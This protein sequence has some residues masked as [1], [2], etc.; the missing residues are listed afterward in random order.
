MDCSSP[1]SSVHGILQTRTLRWVAIPFSRGSSRARDRTCVSCTAGGLIATE[2]QGSLTECRG[3][4][5]AEPSQGQV[6]VTETVSGL[7][8]GARVGAP[9]NPETPLEDRCLRG[10]CAGRAGAP[11]GGAAERSTPTWSVC[12]K[13]SVWVAALFDTGSTSSAEEQSDCVC[14][15]ACTCR[16]RLSGGSPSQTTQ[17]CFSFEGI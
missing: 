17:G 9:G 7:C 15:R 14:V 4:T 8:R 11:T 13:N 12:L 5:Q 1:G 2:P 16:Q 3:S 6:G 10:C